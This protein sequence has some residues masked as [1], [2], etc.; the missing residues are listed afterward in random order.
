MQMVNLDSFPILEYCANCGMM[1][2]SRHYFYF[3]QNNHLPIKPQKLLVLLSML[4]LLVTMD[5]LSYWNC[6]SVFA[7][8]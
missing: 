4:K 5:S 7:T 3:V 8:M 1:L 2:V 6:S